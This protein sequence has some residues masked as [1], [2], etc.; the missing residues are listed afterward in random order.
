MRRWIE[1]LLKAA[2]SIG[3]L[4][5][6]LRG[7]VLERAIEETRDRFELPFFLLGLA[8]FALSNLL[9][10]IQWNLLLRAQEIV[11]STWRAVSLYFV[12]LFFSNFLP[13]NLGG[14]VVKVVDLYRETGKGGG[15]VAATVVDR[16]AG[17]IVLSLMACV[18]GF[19]YWKWFGFD[20]F[21]YLIPLFFL[22]FIGTGLLVLSNRCVRF[23]ER[24]LAR[25]PI[26]SVRTK[27]EALLQ[28]LFVYRKRKL[29]LLAAF[30][31]ALVVQTLRVLVHYFAARTIGL[32]PPLV[33]FFLFIPIIAVFLALPI[34]INGLG[35]REGLGVYLYGLIGIESEL[36]FTISFLAYV[37]G[38]VVSLLGGVFFIVR[39][40]RGRVT[41]AG[42]ITQE[43]ERSS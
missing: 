29:A 39:P 41:P 8:A 18:S 17:L 1:T 34:S 10:G 20:R 7:G 42:P 3:L 23:L 32:D 24:T 28:A 2:I 4:W 33:L 26:D 11:I 5:F 6:L 9:G 30:C 16:G 13:A 27:G 36:A 31:V 15:A 21:L 12:G 40:N 25:V 38:V 35:I 37:I 14:D 43:A 19:L 22:V